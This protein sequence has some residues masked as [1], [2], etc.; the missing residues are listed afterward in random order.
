MMY[1]KVK[2]GVIILRKV[3]GMP[4]RDTKEWRNGNAAIQLHMMRTVYRSVLEQDYDLVQAQKL[5]HIDPDPSNIL[6]DDP[7]VNLI[8]YGA[9]SVYPVKRDITMEEFEKWFKERWDLLWYHKR[10]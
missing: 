8:D 3:S 6:V 2:R 4:L 9:P 7:G 5:V 1:E 10:P